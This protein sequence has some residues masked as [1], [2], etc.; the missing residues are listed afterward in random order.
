MPVIKSSIKKLRKDRKR[1]VVNDKFRDE[2]KNA[3]RK[4]KKSKTI[5]NINR[6]TSIIDKGVKRNILHKNKA[7]RIKSSLS[8]FA[9]PVKK[10]AKK[11]VKK[12][13]K[14]TKKTSKK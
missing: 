10:G 3:I 11:V 5:L 6:A 2:L 7:A 12:I 14:P 4:A 9:K 8:K 13:S 1:E